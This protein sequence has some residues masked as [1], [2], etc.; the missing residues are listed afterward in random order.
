[1]N[2]LQALSADIAAIASS[3]AH[4]MEK[5]MEVPTAN[6][7]AVA[8]AKVVYSLP[9]YILREAMCRHQCLAEQ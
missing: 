5:G 1:M 7:Q 8:Y 4:V 2:C 9:N 3:S 6:T